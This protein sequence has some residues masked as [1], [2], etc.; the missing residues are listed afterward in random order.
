MRLYYYSFISL[1][2]VCSLQNLQYFFTE[3]FSV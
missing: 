2:I 1:C 3:N